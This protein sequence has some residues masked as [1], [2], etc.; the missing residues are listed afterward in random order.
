ME[1]EAKAV[2]D[3]NPQGKDEK[4]PA[5]GKK[6]K[7]SKARGKTSA[8]TGG[9]KKALVLHNRTNTN[10]ELE[11]PPINDGCRVSLYMQFGV[12]PLP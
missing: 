9:S 5:K 1:D 7:E 12:S 3:G 11:N 10:M 2:E 4:D 8:A 6:P